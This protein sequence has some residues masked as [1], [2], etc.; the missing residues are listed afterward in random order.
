MDSN[1]LLLQNISK[2]DQVAFHKLYNLFGDKVYNIAISYTKNVQEA[3]EITQDVFV[4][5][6]QNA[7]KFKGDSKVS[8]WVY[9]ITVNT[10]LNAV[11]KHKKFKGHNELTESDSV[12]FV[13]PGVKLENKENSKLLFKIIDHLPDQQKTAFIL[14]YIDGLPRQEVADVMEKSLKSV[15]S[16]LQRAKTKLKIELKNLYPDRRF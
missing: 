12:D 14:S 13:H 5:I 16:L 3:E 4:K 11:K 2:G 6:H 15:E 9:R 7:G 8:T 10:A 1:L